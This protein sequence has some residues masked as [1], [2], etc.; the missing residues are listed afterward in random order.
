[1][2]TPQRRPDAG[3][4]ERLREAPYK[5]EFFQAVRLLATHFRQEHNEAPSRIIGE[6]I[7][8]GNSLNIGFAPSEI[9]ALDFDYQEAQP[10]APAWPAEATLPASE[11]IIAARL[12]PSFI[13]L[14]GNNGTLPRGYTEDLIER[15]LRK[16]DK[17]A[18]AF[19]DIFSNRAVAL[20]Y[21]AWEKHRL[22]FQYERNRRERFLPMLLS[23]IGVGN[24]GTQEKV[25]DPARQLMAETLAYYA[26]ALRQ[27]ARP[28][29]LIERIV[30]DYFRVPVRLR[31]FVGR[32][33][34]L[35]AAQQSMLGTANMSLGVDTVCG[36]RMW[37]CQTGIAL[38]IGPLARADF[39]RFLPGGEAARAITSLLAMLTGITLDC[40][41]RPTLRRQDVRPTQLGGS[42]PARL[43]HNT[44]MLTRMTQ[45]DRSDLAWEV[46]H[47]AA[48]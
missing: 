15:E 23:L 5:F 18:R 26:G 13:G 43:G 45:E 32:W 16:R 6:R 19:L 38:E 4:I 7:R 17:G 27:S 14:T 9:E 28:A 3:V 34:D 25:C 33:H 30:A 48:A 8:F 12:T 21:R 24:A 11:G 22:H 10:E 29:H 37:Q 31:Q 47:D 35:P 1:M 36:T 44:W 42:I 39:D 41:V 2:P 40:T 20:F 46:R